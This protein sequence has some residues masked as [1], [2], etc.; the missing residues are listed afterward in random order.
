MKSEMVSFVIPTYNSERTLGK[1]IE[2]VM[3][4]KVKKEVIVVDDG[5]TDGTENLMKKFGKTV[6]YFRYENR[7]PAS[8]RNVGLAKGKGEYIAFVDSDVTLPKGW[9]EKALRLLKSSGAAGVGGPGMSRDK[10]VVAKSLNVLL[11]G[12]TA[13]REHDVTSIATMDVIYKRVAIGDMKFDESFTSS[14]GEDPDFNFRLV[15]K[16]YRLLF[17]PDMWVQH[18]HPTSIMGIIKK[19]YNYGRHYPLLYSKHKELRGIEY[20]ARIL[21]VPL[22]LIFASLSFMNMLF[23]Y[24]FLAQVL[25]LYLAYMWI[26]AKNGMGLMTPV[27]SAIHTLKQL[28]QLFGTLTGLRRAF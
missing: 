24:A 22:L 13:G 1:C 25:V 9:S 14:S 21:Y 18:D 2:S 28:A 6:K 12:E 5:S 17:S 8:A 11:Y 4:Q 23:A 19:W 16:G 15:K 3:S 27:F 20:Y 10:G 7:G 26:G